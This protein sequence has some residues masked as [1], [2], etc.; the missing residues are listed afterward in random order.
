MELGSIAKAFTDEAIFYLHSIHLLDLNDPITKYLPGA[1]S[2]WSKITINNLM[3]HTSGIREYLSDPR[4]KADDIFRSLPLDQ[5]AD[6]FLNKIS[7]DSL[8]KMFYSL[9]LDFRPGETW[10]YSNTGYIL[11]GKIGEIVSGKPF[12]DLVREVLTNPLKMSHT[13]ANE[14]ASAEGRLLPGYFQND[15]GYMK[16][17]PVLSS[18]YAFSAGGWATSG[19]DMINYIKAIHCKTLPSDNKGS[20]WRSYSTTKLLPFT[21]HFG[22][23]YSVYHGRHLYLHNGGTPGFSSSWIYVKE[24]TISIIIMCNR[25]D[26]APIDQL[27][28]KILSLYDPFLNIPNEIITGKKEKENVLLIKKILKAIQQNKPLPK[29]LS[30]PL[31]IFMKSESGRG[32]WKWV[33]EKGFPHNV[34]CVDKEIIGNLKAYRFRLSLNLKTEYRITAIINEN[35]KLTQLLWW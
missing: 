9:P 15:S 6:Y 34:Y 2:E 29:G 3:E 1:P 4:F 32:L 27:A 17:S 26:Y 7:T 18:N 14:L 10:S 12:F 31:R 30:E 13:E 5:T 11:L 8:V 33:F 20:G 19:L 24:D 16:R 25:Q 28:W 21:Y 22:R 35:N 23:F